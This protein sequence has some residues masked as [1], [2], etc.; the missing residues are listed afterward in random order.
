M[1][2]PLHGDGFEL[3][4]KECTFKRTDDD[5]SGRDG[6]KAA[7]IGEGIYYLS[8]HRRTRARQSCGLFALLISR[9]LRAVGF[10]RAARSRVPIFVG[11]D[12]PRVIHG[13][14][15]DET[16]SHHRTAANIAWHAAA[17]CRCP[18]SLRW[19]FPSAG[20]C[21]SRRVVYERDSGDS[22][23]W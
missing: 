19:I 9:C 1:P 10:T 18:L 23:R 3:P 17:S 8:R 2:L 5:N 22:S 11:P 6:A 7:P 16:T 13:D 15:D 21:E 12:M 4:P 20:K 14:F